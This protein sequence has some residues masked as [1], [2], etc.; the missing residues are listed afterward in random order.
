MLANIIAYLTPIA[1][2]LLI[3]AFVLARNKSLLFRLFSVVT[4]LIALWL[5]FQFLT[6]IFINSPYALL[7]LEIGTVVPNFLVVAF[8][9]FS[10]EYSYKKLSNKR[11]LLLLTPAVIMTPLSFMGLIISNV[12]VSGNSFE[13]TAGSFY[14]IQTIYLI[15]YFLYA[16][17][18]IVHEYRK[19]KGVRKTQ[20]GLILLSF[21]IPIIIIFITGYVLVESPVAQ[22]FGPSAFLIL[23][24]IIAYAIVKHKL[25]DIRLVVAR[26]LAYLG[27][28]MTL[29]FIYGFIAFNVVG[30]FVGETSANSTGVK[31]LYVALAVVLAFTFQPLKNF[32]DKLTN[33][34]F[35]RD[36][37][38]LKST[39]DG[40]SSVLVANVDLNVVLKSAQ[41]LL[42]VTVKPLYS[43]YFLVNEGKT[44]YEFDTRGKDFE[45]SKEIAS[46]GKKIDRAIIIQDEL[47]DND[48]LKEIMIQNEVSVIQK[49]ETHTG[50]VGFA[51]L[52]AK[53]SGGIYNSQDV[54][55]LT[56]M[57]NEL[58]LAVQNALRFEEISQFN[59]TL[60][61][62]VDDATAEL[63][64][65]N[66]KLKALDQ[67]KDEF[68]S[69]ASHQLRTPLTSVKGYV[70]MVLD[71]DVGKIN[72][73]QKELLDQ[74]FTSSQRMVY[75]IS[76]LLNVSRLRTGKFVIENK[77]TNLAELVQGE[78]QQLTEAAA[79][80]DLK[81]VYKKP[82]RFPVVMM[83]ETKI[84]QVVMNF[85]DNAL[86][87]T[88]KGGTI[89]VEIKETPKSIEFTST[90]TGIGISK[91]AQK[92]LFG[93]FFRAD[94]A[95]KARPD[96]TGLGLYMA[97]KVIVAQGG[98][99]I[100]HSEEGKGSTFGFSLAKNEKDRPKEKITVDDDDDVPEPVLAKAD[101]KIADAAGT[102]A[103]PNPT[104]ETPM[105]SAAIT[106][107]KSS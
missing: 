76:D 83:D 93:K 6:A 85:V 33:K 49:L 80:R 8:V 73:Q 24:G 56:I 36:A 68:I 58:A 21:L 30:V 41:G 50:L 15:G 11:L 100:F 3:S 88:P 32:F 46:L 2:I 60:Q 79:A 63:Q 37:Y 10:S 97:K 27:A 57:G 31:S 99:L 59:I 96:G 103:S 14:L 19:A 54:A 42:D 18:M 40:F 34:L 104:I 75:L 78:I 53:K 69:M 77:E 23:V 5:F 25:F 51:Y 87:Y 62:K 9:Q 95:K 89:T 92:N 61:K 28:L 90:D 12:K 86:Y 82:K 13:T 64:K 1:G 43:H 35:Y 16:L 55:L 106:T 20:T 91:D 22:L 71:G 94:N 38:D 7:L 70:S 29:G 98:S 52:G 105:S 47:A 84:Q 45:V 48:S 66:D 81:L 67:A 72:K 26:S 65:T 44:P 101:A 102:T 39:L 17:S 107:P 4:I 74:A